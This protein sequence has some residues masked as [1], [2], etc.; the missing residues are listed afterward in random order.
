MYTSIYSFSYSLSV[1]TITEYWGD[2]LCYIVVSCWLSILFSFIINFYCSILAFQ[3]YVSFYSTAKWISYICIY[4]PPFWIFFPSRSPQSTEF[5][6]LHNQFSLVMYLHRV[7]TVYMCHFQSL[8][9]SHRHLPP[10]YLYVI[11]YICVFTSALQV[12]SPVPF[13]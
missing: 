1:Y 8:N 13:F 6:V 10:Y 5:P 9:S 12:W 11:L 7:S 2:S 4:P 3:C